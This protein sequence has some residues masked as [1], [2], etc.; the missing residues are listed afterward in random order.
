M[1][2]FC[3]LLTELTSLLKCKRA[4]KTATPKYP[5]SQNKKRGVR[6]V[7]IVAGLADN[8]RKLESKEGKRALYRNVFQLI[9]SAEP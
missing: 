1:L 5:R 3:E 8:V 7:K 9:L 4:L 6:L 2:S